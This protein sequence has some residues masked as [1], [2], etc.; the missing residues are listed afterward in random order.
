MHQ[1][2]Y[3]LQSKGRCHLWHHQRPALDHPMMMNEAETIRKKTEPIFLLGTERSIKLKDRS[4][5]LSPRE[6]E[7]S[8][9]FRSTRMRTFALSKL[10]Q[11]YLMYQI[12][13][14]FFVMTHGTTKQLQQ[15]LPTKKRELAMHHEFHQSA[16]LDSQLTGLLS[17]FLVVYFFFTISLCN[18]Y[19]LVQF[20]WLPFIQF[21]KQILP[22]NS[23]TCFLQ[24]KTFQKLND[25]MF[26]LLLHRPYRQG[27]GTF[28]D[29]VN[30]CGIIG[31]FVL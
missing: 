31:W 3:F 22:K 27:P 6:Q 4:Q 17:S 9:C 5:K 16:G 21:L 19:H 25:S 20:T 30:D 15:R 11:W 12:G 29:S 14:S 26:L 7:W 1:I 28:L 24:N 23:E 10:M 13:L 2:K 8:R 18:L